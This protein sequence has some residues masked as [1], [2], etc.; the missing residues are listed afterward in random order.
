MNQKKVYCSISGHQ[1]SNKIQDDKL[2]YQTYLKLLEYFDEVHIFARS[3]E[4]NDI[5]VYNNIFF[6]YNKVPPKGF[7]KY[8]ITIMKIIYNVR[9]SYNK[10]K[11]S[12]LDASEPTTGGVS[13]IVLSWL[14]NIPLVIQV[15][16]EL[17]RIPASTVGIIKSKG[18]RFL[19][20][21]SC[22]KA[23]I[24]RA[25][26]ESIKKQLTEDGIEPCKIDVITPR[27]KLEN[28]DYSKHINAQDEIRIKYNISK[29]KKILLFVGR[30]VIFK[31]V[32]YLLEAISKIDKS[33]YHLLIVG[34]GELNDELQSLSK[35]LQLES[36]VTFVGKVSFDLVPYY[37][38]ACDI[39][40]LSSL[41]E[42]FGRVLIEAM[43]MKKLVIS[44]KVGGTK[45]IIEDEKTGFFMEKAN[46]NDFI[47]VIEKVLDLNDRD[48]IKV[49]EAAYDNVVNKYEFNASMNKF[50][51][52]YNKVITNEN[53]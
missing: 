24:I 21:F 31:G 23:T 30:L 1:L 22:K 19:T 43:A 32:K 18:F 9:K 4:R 6:H 3:Y 33:K 17:T 8:F 46:I 37:M 13:G 34:D 51:N 7:F 29:N 27:V 16:G 12:L 20:L 2:N 41:D 10:Y 36:N 11:F 40:I 15:Q 44:T 26:S 45:D 38:S 53:T 35:K 47:K 14:L 52:M 49:I 42:G 48:R 28:F 50:I 5:E 25:V 39:F